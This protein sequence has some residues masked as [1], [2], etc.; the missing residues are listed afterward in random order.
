MKRLKYTRI[1]FLFFYVNYALGQS[2][3]Y[4]DTVLSK[5]CSGTTINFEATFTPGATSV[6]EY[7]FNDG[8]RP[9]G[10]DSSPYLVAQPCNPPKGVRSPPSNYFWATTL[11]SG[12]PNNGRRFVQTSAVDVSEGGSIEFYI[13]YGADD[14]GYGCED[15]DLAN[16]EVYLQYKVDGGNWEDMYEDWNTVSNKSAAW[17]NWYFQS[18]PIPD[19]AK[20]IS[21]SFRWYQPSNS[22]SPWDNWGLD[23][24]VVKA[25]SPPSASWEA[26]YSSLS[27]DTFS[28]PSNTVSFTKLFPASNQDK[29]YSVTISTTLTNGSIVA[30]KKD[31]TVPASDNIPPVVDPVPTLTFNTDTGSCTTQL[32]LAE[33]GTVSV[34]ESCTYLMVNDNPDLLFSIG[35][36]TL[37]WTITDAASNSTVVPQIILVLDNEDPILTIPPDIVTGTCSVSIGI[38]SATDNC[39]SLTPANNAPNSFPLGVSAVTW[40]VTDS[41][42]NTVSATQLITV[43]DT[44]APV[45][46]APLNIV[47]ST[48]SSSCN[49]INVNLGT[50]VT[51]DNCTISGISNDAPSIFPTGTTT[52]TWTVSDTAGNISLSYQMV[53]VNDNI[54]P[55]IVA[56][57]D[58]T[59]SDC[60]YVLGNPSITDNCSY[61][62]SN[63]A[64]SSFPT[65]TTIVTWTASDTSGNT[66]SV[67]QLVTLT[68]STNPVIK[69]PEE[70]IIITINTDNGSCFATGVNLG[71]VLVNDDC[72]GFTFSNDAPLSFP[73]GTK[74]ITWTASDTAGNISTATQTVIVQD[75]EPPVARAR[76]IEVVIDSQSQLN[77][78]WEAIN[79]GS[80]DNC[81]PLK[82]F[83]FE[84]EI[85]GL[86]LP[87]KKDVPRTS[88]P[89]P[90]DKNTSENKIQSSFR[91][92]SLIANCDNLGEKEITFSVFDSS[93][94]KGSTSVKIIIT[95]D[96]NFCGPPPD[97]STLD[98]DNDGVIDS[99]DAFPNNPNEW[100]DSDG[101][102]IGNNSDPD[103]D[104]DGFDDFTEILAGSDSE[105]FNSIPIDTDG[106]GIINLLD[107]DDDN[108]GFSDLIEKEIGT[109]PL[110]I[111]NFPIDT[112]GD[113]VLDFYDLDDDNDGQSDLIELEC[114]SEPKNPYSKSDDTDFDG[115]PDCLDI[116]DDNDGF[117]DQYEI[118]QG[119][120]PL[121]VNEF[122]FPDNDGD[123]VPYYIGSVQRFN[124]NCPE[125]PNS[126]QVDT[127]EDGVGDACDNCINIKNKDQLDFD[128]D[129]IGDLC[130][131]CP[132]D[133]NP[134]QE[135]YD[136][137]LLGDI[138][139]LDDD[140]DGQSDE[141][142]IECG[143]DPKDETSLSP[144]YDGD[145][146][147]DCLDLDNDND[148]IEDSIDLNPSSF[149]EL[150]ISQYVSDN[151]DG[152]N[153]QF[154]LLKID[155][156]P[157]NLLS[158]YSRSGALVYSKINYQNTWPSDVA[159]KEFPEGSYFFRLDL[160]QDG[161]IDYQGWLYL[162]R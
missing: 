73:I 106:D 103:D 131:V 62:F 109:D 117:E 23:D 54:P 81:M 115:I 123:G 67:T 20:S 104:A 137:D 99:L 63:D 128:V 124:D 84:T 162:T 114:G 13:R 157:N 52:V 150:L 140:N 69:I 11:Q 28:I 24:I 56:P 121:N 47:T 49:A 44:T 87:D 94:N 5:T 4:S 161:N 29:V 65:G 133:F 55:S 66:V 9:V 58:I 86:V 146:I 17:Y 78:S 147:L 126:S 136:K 10:W 89:P 149:D 70:S 112:D 155:N 105:E 91:G 110:N 74:I 59:T 108:D 19:G 96:Q 113:L 14:P 118:S 85:P 79:N 46:I 12:G 48:T 134:G 21:T 30:T 100:K 153:D 143:S 75:T 50:P 40:Q 101:D 33:L 37:I 95:D 141:D 60:A 132:E 92:K 16:E 72:G 158:I 34:T 125:I 71:T 83:E 119:T 18:V 38:A 130:D 3:N 8:N 31:I 51:S 97:P 68:D 152:I 57:S 6:T 160:E 26:G 41:S 7:D 148:E 64:P 90:S 93:G 98:T 82:S 120:N 151:G 144:D 156:Y 32:T 39:G 22:G 139:D 27:S 53:T 45:N 145:G 116:D 2:V 138:C 159:D 42:G 1:I 102:G 43:S 154:I 122:P 135:D 107:D 80:S 142:E 111:S 61:T 88:Y 36:N 127:D 15:P 129:G 77:I 25:I 35:S 76:N